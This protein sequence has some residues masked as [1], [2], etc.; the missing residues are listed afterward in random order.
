MNEN[1]ATPYPRQ[2]Q[3]NL[4]SSSTPLSLSTNGNEFS[5][6]RH[7]RLFCDHTLNF[8]SAIEIVIRTPLSHGESTAFAKLLKQSP[9]KTLLECGEKMPNLFARH[10]NVP[11]LFIC[12]L[13]SR[14]SSDKSI[15][16]ESLESLRAYARLME[17]NPSL[18]TFLTADI[19]KI[20][21]SLRESLSEKDT[22]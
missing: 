15:C 12:E 7:S 22:A 13:E 14:A 1:L 2:E 10:S 5:Q 8:P 3:M 9:L 19:S 6:A 18:A 20:F 16:P 17:R 4:Q 21:R 11:Q